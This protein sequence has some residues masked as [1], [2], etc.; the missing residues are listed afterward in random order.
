MSWFSFNKRNVVLQDHALD[1]IS[2]LLIL[3]ASRLLPSSSSE[4][5]RFSDLSRL[6]L[7]INTGDFDVEHVTPLL[8]AVLDDRPD[9]AIWERVYELLAELQLGTISKSTTPPSSDPSH[10]ASFQQTPWSFHTGS[11]ADTSDLRRNVD[12]ILRSE[13]EDNLRIDHPDVFDVFFGQIQ[14]LDIITTVVLSSC[15][16]V[17][18]HCFRRTQVG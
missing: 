12:P 17:E 16:S 2:A 11:L 1:L 9:A 3:P 7:A 5:N 6:N 18:P 10:T 8:I 15:K 13:V 14:G 4:K